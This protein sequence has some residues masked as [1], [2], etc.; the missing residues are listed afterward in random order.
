MLSQLIVT[1]NS[2]LAG[3][4][5]QDT[6]KQPVPCAQQNPEE[7]E[8]QSASRDTAENFLHTL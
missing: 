6:T 1:A 5:G 7:G 3:H 2:F 4:F 8:G